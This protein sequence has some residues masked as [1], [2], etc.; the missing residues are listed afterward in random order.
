MLISMWWYLAVGSFG[1]WWY[2]GSRTLMNGIDAVIGE[3]QIILSFLEWQRKRSLPETKTTGT[4]ISTSKIFSK[5]SVFRLV[6]SLLPRPNFNLRRFWPVFLAWEYLCFL[7]KCY[8]L[9]LY[10]QLWLGISCSKDSLVCI[11]ELLLLHTW[12]SLIWV[13]NILMCIV[14]V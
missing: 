10:D 12:L 14:T 13:N 3:S 11:N 5:E 7:G 9:G 2:C 1:R 6:N 4:R 8:F